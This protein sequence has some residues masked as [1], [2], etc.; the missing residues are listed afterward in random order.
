MTDGNG[1]PLVVVTAKANVHDVRLAIPTLDRLLIGN[2][3]RRPKRSRMDKGYDSAALRR[4]LKQRGIIPA[5]DHR[6]F[7]NRR[8]PE[9]MWNDRREI[10]YSRPRWKV[11]Q[12]IACLDQNRRLGYLYERTR[13][14]YESFL[15]LARIRCYVRKLGR[16]RKTKRGVFR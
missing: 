7:G 13:A 1:L 11:E 3:T 8:Q 6:E 4:Q 12:C 16:C 10:R 14:T 2:R 5:I 9:R 15:T